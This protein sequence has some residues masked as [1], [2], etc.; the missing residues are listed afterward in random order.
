MPDEQPQHSP[1][2]H[3]GNRNRHPLLDSPP[4][5]QQAQAAK[6]TVNLR[7]PETVTVPRLTYLLIG[8]NVFIWSL[9]FFVPEFALTL[10]SWAI[11]DVEAVL[12]NREIHRLVTAMF[13]HID[14]YHILFNSMAL[15]YIGQYVERFFG[16]RRFIIIYLLGGVAG[17]ILSLFVGANGLGASG[18][19][20]AIWAAEAVF[21][22]QHRHL[23]GAVAMQRLRMTT[24]IIA[25]NFIFG[26]WANAAGT[27]N[28]GNFAHLG[29]LIGGAILAWLIGPR[30]VA[31][32]LK[33]PQP[34]QTPVQIVQVNPLERRVREILFYSAGLAAMLLI[35]IMLGT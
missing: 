26:F 27:A 6:K 19:V 23:F 34:Q 9:R 15:Y 2:E 33:D 20:M 12:Q 16:P 21:W 5:A 10:F 1:E 8:I 11:L 18:A 22:Y 17:S 3:E 29:G 24:I 30:F 28:I 7:F 32:R 4:P 13:L 14:G 35:A 31:L 25:M